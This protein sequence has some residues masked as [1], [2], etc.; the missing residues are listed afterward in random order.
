MN[1]RTP[2]L[3]RLVGCLAILTS[4]LGSLQQAHAFCAWTECDS[5]SESKPCAACQAKKSCCQSHNHAP[6][7]AIKQN[8][9]HHET[10]QH[11][12]V[13]CQEHCWCCRQSEPVNVPNDSS[14]NAKEILAPSTLSPVDS[15]VVALVEQF[16]AHAENVFDDAT[17]P[18]AAQFC[19]QLCRFRI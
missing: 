7:P 14:T 13:P 9:C 6:S 17:T 8:C 12:Q 5:A 16:A 10:A 11:R 18:S 3:R 19:V 2:K 15:V 1:L 4:L